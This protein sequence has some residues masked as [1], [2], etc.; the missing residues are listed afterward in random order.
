MLGFSPH[1]M[2]LPISLDFAG[3]LRMC[4]RDK[5]REVKRDQTNTGDKLITKL[6]FALVG[7]GGAGKGVE[8]A[9]GP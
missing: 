5:P 6:A 3:G 8:R 1:I 9:G 4:G 2:A 7:G